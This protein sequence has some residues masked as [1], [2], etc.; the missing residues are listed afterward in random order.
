MK[1]VLKVCLSSWLQVWLVQTTD[2]AFSHKVWDRQGWARQELLDG[3]EVVQD[4]LS[5]SDHTTSPHEAF[6]LP[7]KKKLSSTQMIQDNTKTVISSCGFLELC[8]VLAW[9]D[10]PRL[11]LLVMSSSFSC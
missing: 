9:L 11:A 6:I 2:G 10:Q 3:T 7:K 1:H 8:S 5:A 4:D